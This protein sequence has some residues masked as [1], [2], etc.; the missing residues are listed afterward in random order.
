ME[1]DFE[2]YETQ[3]IDQDA[4]KS[5]YIPYNFEIIN[6]DIYEL[7]KKEEFFEN[8]NEK[9]EKQ[10]CYQ[11]LF[12]NNHIIIKNKASEKFEGKDDYSNELLFY[13]KNIEKENNKD[14]HL[15]EYILNFEIMKK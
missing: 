13:K 15:L 5:Y 3:D 4:A 2:E 9:I 1:N 14:G 12:W 6:E 8:F 7:I 10:I 11:I